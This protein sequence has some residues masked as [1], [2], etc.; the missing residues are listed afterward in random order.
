MSDIRTQLEEITKNYS[1][2]TDMERLVNEVIKLN[3]EDWRNSNHKNKRK[4]ENLIHEIHKII[5]LE[6]LGKIRYEN[7]KYNYPQTTILLN[8]HLMCDVSNDGMYYNF[9]L[10][11]MRNNSSFSYPPINYYKHPIS[12]GILTEEVIEMIVKEMGVGITQNSWNNI[13]RLERCGVI[14]NLQRDIEVV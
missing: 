2:L 9:I 7:R 3:Y 1:N 10:I 11:R 4:I 12:E 13:Y 6:N 5:P 8:P 14:N